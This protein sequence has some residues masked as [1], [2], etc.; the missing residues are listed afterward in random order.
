[1]TTDGSPALSIPLPPAPNTHTHTHAQINGRTFQIEKLLGEGGFSFVYLARDSS[2]S[3]QFALKKIR[4][5]TADVVKLALAE[6]DAYKRFKS[7]NIIR[8][9]LAAFCLLDSERG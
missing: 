7:D 6:V 1:M 4:C 9:A 2:S 3:R 5:P 8:R